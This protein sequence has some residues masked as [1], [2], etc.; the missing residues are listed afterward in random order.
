M[1][2]ASPPILYTFRRNALILLTLVSVG[3]I[4]ATVEGLTQAYNGY[5]FNH[6]SSAEHLRQAKDVCGPNVAG[7]CADPD[8]ALRHLAKIPTTASEYGEASKIAFSIQ[9]QK[10]RN[11]EEAKQKAAESEEQSREQMLRNVQGVIHDNFSCR[12]LADNEL[13][14]LPP[15]HAL[16]EPSIAVAM[17]FDGGQHWWADDGRCAAL[18]A[19]VQAAKQKA[20]QDQRDADAKLYSYWSTTVRV[21]TDMDSFSGLS[22]LFE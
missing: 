10:Q 7:I 9:Q 18:P 22:P 2:G 12:V 1:R 19:E 3:V 6:L 21:D 15:G 20:E 5:R 17:S 11:S 16:E 13:I 14:S 4:T 8:D